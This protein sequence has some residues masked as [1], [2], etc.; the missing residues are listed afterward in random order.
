MTKVICP[1]NLI[2]DLVTDAFVGYGVPREEA[3]I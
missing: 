1:W 3:E 2:S